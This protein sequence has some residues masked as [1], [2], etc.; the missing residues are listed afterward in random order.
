[1]DRQTYRPKGKAPADTGGRYLR[2]VSFNNTG[3]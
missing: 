3:A 2:G 1:M